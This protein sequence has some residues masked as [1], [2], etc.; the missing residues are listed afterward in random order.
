M[1]ARL[2]RSYWIA[3]VIVTLCAGCA[4]GGARDVDCRA[5]AVPIN[6]GALIKTSDVPD[7]AGLGEH[8]SRQ[9]KEYAE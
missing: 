6:G 8:D 9:G 1:E 5:R 4:S 7:G 2:F 3:A